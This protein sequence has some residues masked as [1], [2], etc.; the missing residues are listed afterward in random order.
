MKSNSL[1]LS[2]SGSFF[3]NGAGSSL[4]N[5]FNQLSLFY[6]NAADL[7]WGNGSK[8]KRSTATGSLS[9]VNDDLAGIGKAALLFQIRELHARNEILEM[10]SKRQEA[11]ISEKDWLLREVHHRVKN[12]FQTSMSLLSLQSGHLSNPEAQ[13]ALLNSQ[14]RMQTMALVHQRLYQSSDFKL[15]NLKS[16]IEDLIVYLKQGFENSGMIRYKVNI[17]SVSLS[18]DQAVP[19]GLILNEAITNAFKYAFQNCPGNI[20]IELTVAADQ[21]YCLKITDDG[22]GL[23]PSFDPELSASLGIK[24]MRGL[25]GQLN[26]E[27]TVYN[28]AGTVIAITFKKLTD[29]RSCDRSA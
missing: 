8:K 20:T 25:A 27:F 10:H 15:V 2:G 21:T 3:G 19:L 1:T 23:P 22:I 11:T 18:I 26:G 16:Y 13:Q 5:G 12:N 14:R 28:N 7:L 6:R 4:T 29:D 9:N 17:P 24:L